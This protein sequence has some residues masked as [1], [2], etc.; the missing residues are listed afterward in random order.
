MVVDGTNVFH[1]VDKSVN[2][3][4]HKHF[5]RRYNS[6]EFLVLIKRSEWEVVQWDPPS[7]S[8]LAGEGQVAGRAWH[9]QAAGTASESGGCLRLLAT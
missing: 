4:L 6:M 3:M 1:S 7:I 9:T 8:L 2:F 5:F